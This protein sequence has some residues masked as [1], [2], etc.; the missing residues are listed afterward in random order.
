MATFIKNRL[1]LI[2][3]FVIAWAATSCKKEIPIQDVYINNSGTYKPTPYIIH[4]P[5]YFPTLMN[6]SADNPLTV[7]GIYLGRCLFYDRRM[8]GKSIPD[9][10]MTC[11]TCHIQENAFECGTNGPFPGGH[12][13]G[14]TGI[15]T[16]HVMLPMFNLVWQNNGYFWN[17]L[18]HPDNPNPRKRR[19]ED[20]VWMGVTAPHEMYSDTNDA[21]EAIKNIPGYKPLFKKAFGTDTITFELM[22]KAIA[23][24]IR[25][26]V[27]YNSKFDQYLQGQTSLTPSEMSGFTLFVTENGAD[28]F[29][30]HG[31]EGNPL[32]S[33]YL[34]YNNGKDTLFND[35]RDRFAVTGDP[36]DH[37]AYKAPSL[38]NIE[39]TGPYM[40]DGRFQTLDQVIDFYSEGL[41]W[42]PSVSPLMHKINDGGAHLTPQQKANLKAFL[43][44]L[45]DH[46]LLTNPDY[47]E[48]TVLP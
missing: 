25:S 44:T 31:G 28:C 39:L 32:F 37:G 9:S 43:L 42:S 30:C 17:G 4:A 12:P 33:T 23:Q 40:H 5:W 7:E 3:L 20:V 2:L 10:Q 18:I 29:H 24:F 26:I 41:V 8:S 13:Y 45:T 36:M 38:R 35:P 11:A 1:L 21:R 27:S 22:S 48:P 47:A 15:S 16:P 34:F 6:I 46:T 14:I 19:L